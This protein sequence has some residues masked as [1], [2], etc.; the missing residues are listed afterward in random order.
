[1]SNHELLNNFKYP[2]RFKFLTLKLSPVKK[3]MLV[4]P[5]KSNRSIFHL[6]GIYILTPS[7][8]WSPCDGRKK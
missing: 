8:I 6:A 7:F 5:R 1:Q 3:P 2:T 4:W